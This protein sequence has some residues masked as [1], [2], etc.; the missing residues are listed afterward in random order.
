MLSS[1]RIRDADRRSSA[2]SSAWTQMRFIS[3][4]LSTHSTRLSTVQRSAG[5]SRP[6]SLT[7]RMAIPGATLQIWYSGWPWQI[8]VNGWW[9]NS[10][11]DKFISLSVEWM[12][13]GTSNLTHRLNMKSIRQCIINVSTITLPPR[14]IVIR[15]SLG[16]DTDQ[17]N[18][19]WV[20]TLWVHYS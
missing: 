14:F 19:A 3:S 10:K 5:T 1:W 16:G 7:M 15:Y 20:R 11:C 9:I 4:N 2:T 6:T 18:T 17:S 13:L 12:K 8:L